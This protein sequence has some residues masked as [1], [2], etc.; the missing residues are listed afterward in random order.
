MSTTVLYQ[1][2][3][4]VVIV[5][6]I[7]FVGVLGIAWKSWFKKYL[8]LFVTFAAGTLVATALLQMIPEAV[9]LAGD[10]I[11]LWA[12]I[13]I[14]VFMILE[15]FLFWYHCHH[16]ECSYHKGHKKEFTYLN[17]FGDALHNLIDGAVIAIAFA[18]S[19]ELGFITTIA[20]VLHEIPQEIGDFAI[21]MHGGFSKG[22]ALFFNFLSALTAVLGAVIAW[23]FIGAFEY[24][25]PFAIAFAA[26]G[27]LYIALVD[28]LPEIHHTHK[29]WPALAQALIFILGVAVIFAVGTI[30]PHA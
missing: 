9:E 18:A 29:L 13:G 22:K 12:I 14:T 25:E 3:I 7:S 2:L 26:G 17:L 20:V 8:Y 6:L 24:I 27:F 28:L 16:S 10:S 11:F 30:M 5:S 23:F 4:A 19:F 21:L 1:S 15:R